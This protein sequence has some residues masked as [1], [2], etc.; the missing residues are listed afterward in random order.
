MTARELQEIMQAVEPAAVLVAPNVLDRIIRHTLKL[1]AWMWKVPHDQAF[2]VERQFLF[3]YVEQ[4]DLLLKH[5]QLLPATVL[6][7]PV[8]EAAS[9]S[10]ERAALL[11]DYWRRLFHASIDRT[12]AEQGMIG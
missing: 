12:L 4:E 6:L 5:D 9:D 2:I 11:L 1:P 10:G 8:P 3:R 7:F